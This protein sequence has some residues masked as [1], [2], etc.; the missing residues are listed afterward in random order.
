MWKPKIL[1]V[2]DELG[3]RESY[4]QIL[5]NDYEVILMDH[6]RLAIEYVT[7]HPVDVALVDIRM[8]DI[9]GIEVL[10][11]IKTLQPKIE[12][13]MITAFASVENAKNAIKYG[14]M[15]YL[16][17]PAS[18]KEIQ[19]T[20][21]KAVARRIQYMHYNENLFW[22]LQVSQ[23][24]TSS[25]D[26]QDVRKNI[27]DWVEKLFLARMA[28]LALYNSQKNSRLPTGRK[29]CIE[30]AE[31]R[32]P[33]SEEIVNAF[34]H[35]GEG[36]TEVVLAQKQIIIVPDVMTDER[37]SYKDAALKAEIRSIV[38]LPLMIQDKVIG[39]LGFSSPQFGQQAIEPIQMNFL[40][41][42]ANQAAIALENATLYSTL[43]ESLA[44]SMASLKEKEV[45]LSEIHHRVKNN[46]QLIHSLLSLQ[47][48][49][50]KDESYREMFKDIQNRIRSMA[51]IHGELY[52]SEYLAKIDFD[53]YIKHLANS[54][55]RT[56]ET[57][58]KIVLKIEVEDVS[59][60]IN[61]A[62]PCGL[63][64][65]ELISNSLKYAFPEEREGEIKITLRGIE[66]KIELVVSDDGIGV[67]EDLD[68][69]NVESLGLQ[70]VIALVKQL[71]GT[72]KLERNGG[73]TFKITFAKLK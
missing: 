41:I 3:P 14:A 32:G 57:T 6:G 54:L 18:V 69:Q 25:L 53:S 65:N 60:S 23:S 48:R 64:L 27:L 44:Q 72:I 20:V 17:K 46:L 39:V 9:D 13:I 40:T 31:V 22:L 62:I 71:E 52:K 37:V 26:A 10:Q 66:D 50:I 43:Q 34:S 59:L 29:P 1:V 45:L 8:P 4:R 11:K 49:A 73:T 55:F 68:L 36:I 42:F 21:R 67:P 19:A 12:V 15:D 30:L 7:N 5:K 35:G 70:L 63:I 38:S 51:L 58:G 2:E 28:W 61:S 33:I 56:Y 47:E 16:I 24:V